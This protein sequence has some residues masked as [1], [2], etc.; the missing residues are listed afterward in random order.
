MGSATGAAGDAQIT[1]ELTGRVTGGIVVPDGHGWLRTP[2]TVRDA[3]PTMC[4]PHS[5]P[6]RHPS[7]PIRHP[8]S[9]VTIG[10][11]TP[12]D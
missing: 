9:L 6:H 12:D 2:L 3:L 7:L 1:A 4:N 11:L 10:V 5:Q 8:P